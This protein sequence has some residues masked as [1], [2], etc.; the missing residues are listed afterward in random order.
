MQEVVAKV[1][2]ELVATSMRAL[3]C[4]ELQVFQKP[5]LPEQMH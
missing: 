1:S 4:L 3:L 5:T 2:F